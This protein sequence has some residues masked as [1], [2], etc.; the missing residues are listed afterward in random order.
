VT[1]TVEPVDERA[2]WRQL[3]LNLRSPRPTLRLRLTLFNGVLLVGAL[4]A[5]VLLSWLLVTDAL[6]PAEQLAPGTVVVLTDGRQLDA[7]AWQEQIADQASRELL[8]KALVALIASYRQSRCPPPPRPSRS[9]CS[10]RTRWSAGR[11]GP[12]S[13]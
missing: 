12:C 2:R 5:F 13:R 11:C 7:A 6:R 8:A 1:P 10:A 9:G 4:S 3:R